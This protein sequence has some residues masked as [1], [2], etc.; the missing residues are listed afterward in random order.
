MESN[1]QIKYPEIEQDGKSYLY[2][3]HPESEE[4]RELV[5]KSSDWYPE[6]AY[7][8]TK[9]SEIISSQGTPACPSEVQPLFTNKFNGNRKSSQECGTSTDHELHNFVFNVSVLE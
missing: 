4:A 9:Y 3:C 5:A 1:D 8:L 7:C 6:D 2:L